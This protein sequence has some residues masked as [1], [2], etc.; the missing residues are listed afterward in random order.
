M[1]WKA[2]SYQLGEDRYS[3]LYLDPPTN[4][5]PARF[6]E[7]NYGRFGS[8]FIAEATADKPLEVNYRLVIRKGEYSPEECKKISR[9][10]R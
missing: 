10:D 1:P 7:R 5:K 4:P 2:M 6:S 9:A 8:Y 3:V